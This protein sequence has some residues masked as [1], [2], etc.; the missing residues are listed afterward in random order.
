M[1]ETPV[2]T[3]ESSA[4]TQQRRA[5][6]TAAGEGPAYWFFGALAV[7]RSPESA[8]PIVIEMTV[9]PG[10]HTPLHVHTT[11]DDSYF[12]LSGRLAVRCG[13]ETFVAHAG[14][15]VSQPPGV[16]HTFFALDEKP[17]VML[18]T[19]ANDDFLRFIH[20]AGV[21][22]TSRIQPPDQPLDFDA[23]YQVAAATGQPVIGP[24]MTAAEAAMIVSTAER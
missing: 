10:G 22:A 21:P 3:T 23:L 19:H 7:I 16:P 1:N 4:T 8:R 20:Q 6:R 18:Q 24:P 2:T 12:L 9:P 14:D 11:L 13:D 5:T 17:A 15:Y